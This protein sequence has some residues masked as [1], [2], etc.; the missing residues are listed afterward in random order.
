[1]YQK[2]IMLLALAF[3]ITGYGQSIAGNVKS[4]KGENVAFANI[5]VLNAA[6]GTQSDDQ[7]RFAIELNEG[8]YQLSVSAMG[9]AT[10]VKTVMVAASRQTKIQIILKEKSE[11]LGEV[12]VSAE[13]REDQLQR[14]PAAVSVLDAEELKEGRVWSYSDL[15][16]LAPSLNMV[17]HGGSTSSLFVNIRGVMGLHSQPA[18]ATYVDGIYQFESFSVPLT[19]NNVDRIEVLRGPQGTLYG[20]NAFGG[21]INIVTRQP[22]NKANGSVTVGFGNYGQQRYEA[23]YSTPIIKDKLFVN[24]S[25]TFNQHS[26]V[27]TNTLTDHDFDRPQSIAGGINVKYIASAKWDFD[28]NARFE[29]NEDKGSYPWVTSD[30]LLFANPYKVARNQDNTELRKNKNLA[31]KASYRGKRFDFNSIS[32]FQ[33]Y[34]RGFPGFLD[35]DF[36]GA[37]LRKAQNDFDISTFTQ[38]LR[39][40]SPQGNESKFEWTLGTYAW[41]A[42]DGTNTNA[43]ITNSDAGETSALRDSRFDNKGLS[44][45]GQ[46]SYALTDELSVTA[47]LRYNTENRKLSQRQRTR[48]PNGSFTNDTGLVDFEGSFNAFTPKFNLKYQITPDVM[49]Y[50]QYA[51]GFRAGGLNTNASTQADVAY[52]PETSDNYE[53]GL[54]NTFF[55]DKLRLNLTGFYLQQK[56]QQITVVEETLPLTRNTGNMNNLGAELELNALALKGL[57]IQWSASVS[58]AEYDKIIVFSGGEN[59]DFSGNKPLYNPEFA[60]FTAVQYTKEFGKEFEAFIRGE[61]RYSGAYYFDFDNALR[62]S[63]YNVYNGR[64]G[65]H[66]KNLEFAV[67][68]RNLGDI[69]YRTYARNVFLLNQPRMYGATLSYDF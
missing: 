17:E 49:V 44:F 8:K 13:R 55:Q 25:G 46:A 35:V 52:D 65:A 45:Y 36:T 54:K 56:D 18:V 38:E 15:T 32:G 39:L 21:V 14:V 58:N 42:P 27:Y 59:R 34:Q 10:Q 47:G 16:A 51:R 68:G 11:S 7:G 5:K 63:P 29:R 67:W 61:H 33:N 53:I 23:N 48:N 40:S 60:S 9:Y 50:A 41:I 4:G 12:V 30:S 69:K 43:T 64:L 31:L 22:T 37:D 6:K 28:L 2:I 57:Q 66:Y 3:G 26:G 1:M 62:Q 19:F 24:V 20:R